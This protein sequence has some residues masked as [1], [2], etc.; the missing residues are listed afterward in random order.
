MNPKNK[1]SVDDQLADYTDDILN[2]K[3]GEVDENPNTL[4]PEL[5]ALEQTALRLKN[6]FRDDGPSEEVIQRM[7]KNIT[8]QWQ[9][10]ENSRRRPFWKKWLP[11]GQKWQSQRSRQ[12]L[13][14]AISLM[15]LLVLLL[16]CIPFFGGIDFHQ[17][18]TSGQHRNS[19]ILAASVGLGFFAIWLFRRK[20]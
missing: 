8:V 18:A 17:P 13:Y 16:V 5:R 7:R 3:T 11:S 15:T 9:Q 19:I 4:D 20:R 2:E 14:L 1:K 6:A 12:R 10:Q